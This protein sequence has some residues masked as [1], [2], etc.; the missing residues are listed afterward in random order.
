MRI[1]IVGGQN[2]RRYSEST[3]KVENVEIYRKKIIR[4]ADYVI[5]VQAVCSH[6]SMW[7]A[8]AVAKR[9]QKTVYYAYKQSLSSILNSIESKHK[10]K[11]A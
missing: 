2:F 8:K 9:F 10:R 4:D 5:I 1:A 3:T 11:T 6:N 7:D